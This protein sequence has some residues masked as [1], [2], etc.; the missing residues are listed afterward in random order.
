MDKTFDILVQ[1]MAQLYKVGVR[2]EQVEIKDE[3][4]IKFSIPQSSF[5]YKE[6]DLLTSQQALIEEVRDSLL[7]IFNT[8]PFKLELLYRIRNDNFLEKDSVEAEQTVVNDFKDSNFLNIFQQ[9]SVRK[10]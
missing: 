2:I 5:L 9:F 7:K 1:F 3:M 8:L 10:N 4:I 6:N